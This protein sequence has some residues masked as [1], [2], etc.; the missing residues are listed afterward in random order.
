MNYKKIF[1]LLVI[2]LI[3]FN[4]FPII[5]FA[6]SPSITTYSPHCIVM[7]SSTGKIV[8]EKDA[9]S[10]SFPASTTKIMTAILTLEN[11]SLTDTAVVSHNAIYSVPVGYSHAYLV[12]GEILTINQLLHLLLIPSAND[13]ATVL[14]EHIAGSTDSFAS[15]MNTKASE[16]GCKDTHFVNA[17]GIHTENHYSTAYDLAL[18]GRYAMRNETFRKIV[19]TFEY[20]LPATNKYTENNR[21]FKLTNALIIPNDSDSVDNYYYPY[22]TGIKTGFTNA[23]GECIVASSMKDGIEFI[24]V[25]LGGDKTDNGLSARYFDCKNLFNYAFDNYKTYVINEENSVLK[26][27][28]VSGAGIFNKSL[29]VIVQDEI[30]LLIRKDTIISSITP[31]VDISSNLKAPI[32]KNSIIGTIS[33]EIDGNSYTSNL[34]AGNDVDESNFISSVLTIASILIVIFL[35]LRL[36]RPNKKKSAKNKKKTNRD[37]FLYW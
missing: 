28:S 18:I 12:E 30:S 17:N 11:C 25:I 33:Y 20:T 29:D 8:Y 37:N 22:A 3:I 32:S 4:I 2:F 24:V 23:A 14:A 1:F 31:T 36:L 15:M 16:L 34:L 9:Y 5:T 21:F 7:E 13:A 19:T 10:R 6:Q 27:V 26:K 35:L